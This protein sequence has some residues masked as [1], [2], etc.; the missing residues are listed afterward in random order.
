MALR[1]LFLTLFIFG[2]I[3]FILKRPWLG[4][5]MWVWVSV[6]SPHRLSWD[7]AYTMPFA[8]MIALATLLALLLSKEKNKFPWTPVTVVFTLFVLWMNITT[9]FALQ[10]DSAWLEWSTV[11]K[12][13]FMVFVVMLALHTKE[14]IQWLVWAL[15]ISLGFYGV[16]GGI[17]TL[18][19]GA[20]YRVYGPPQSYVEENNALAVAMCMSASLL[21]RPGVT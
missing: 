13:M 5:L 7:F 14:H 3:P 18:V 1:D 16:K 9:L 4:A 8:Q 11:M 12:T 17:F 19:G 2:M 21:R 10:P 6:M 15:V 20:E